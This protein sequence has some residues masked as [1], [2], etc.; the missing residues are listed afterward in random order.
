MIQDHKTDSA[1]F[2][3]IEVIGS[4][5]LVSIFTIIISQLFI[6]QTQISSGWLRFEKAEQVAYNNLNKYARYVSENTNNCT[7]YPTSSSQKT[8]L[9][10]GGAVDGLP[11]PVSQSV[12]SSMPYG[13]SPE[14]ITDGFPI[15]IVSSVT[16]GSPSPK[17]ITYATY[18]NAGG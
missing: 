11:S 17:T 15:K 13:C 7:D 8:L 6:L 10:Q 18:V 4:L 2:T 12:V 5:F 3:I 9:S 14:M 1:G 16:Y